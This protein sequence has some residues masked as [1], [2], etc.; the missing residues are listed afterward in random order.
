MTRDQD[1][2]AVQPP[3]AQT[4]PTSRAPATA[5]IKKWLPVAITTSVVETGYAQARW[6]ARDPGNARTTASATHTAQAT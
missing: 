4:A 1:S 6:R 2:T 5:S 3:M